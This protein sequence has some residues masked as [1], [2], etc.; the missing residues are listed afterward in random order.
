MGWTA[1]KAGVSAD[2]LINKPA[3]PYISHCPPVVDCCRSDNIVYAFVALLAFASPDYYLS[4]ARSKCEQNEAREIPG[5]VCEP[6][7]TVRL[8]PLDRQDY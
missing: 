2:W 1:M 7:R 6:C 4:H 8:T 3:I 5:R